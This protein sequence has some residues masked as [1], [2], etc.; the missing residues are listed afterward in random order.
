MNI[1]TV[2]TKVPPYLFKGRYSLSRHS[3]RGFVS[4][5]RETD[6]REPVPLSF[7]RLVSRAAVRCVKQ[8][9]VP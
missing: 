9:P 2:R 3:H 1:E 6:Q 5:A 8:F 4:A 7:V